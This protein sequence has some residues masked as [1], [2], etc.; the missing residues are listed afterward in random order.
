MKFETK[1]NGIVVGNQDNDFCQVFEGTSTPCPWNAG[2]VTWY[3]Q[4]TVP[5]TAP[6]GK[7]EEKF[8]LVDTTKKQVFCVKGK[9][10]L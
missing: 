4:P 1:Y 3:T 9:F 8:T 5:S 10:T 7:Y 6:S 2:P